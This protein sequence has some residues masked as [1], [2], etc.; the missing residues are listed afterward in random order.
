MF[1]NTWKWGELMVSEFLEAGA[2]RSD[3]TKTAQDSCTKQ[4]RSRFFSFK[5]DQRALGYMFKGRTFIYFYNSGK[6]ERARSRRQCW[7]R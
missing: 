5:P 6:L 3:R 2:R 4:V 1:A 7:P